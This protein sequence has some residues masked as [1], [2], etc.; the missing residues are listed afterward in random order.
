MRGAFRDH[1]EGYLQVVEHYGLGERA[2]STNARFVHT[3]VTGLLSTTCCTQNMAEYPQ[4][5]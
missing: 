3:R 5:L 4:N 2:K 1:A